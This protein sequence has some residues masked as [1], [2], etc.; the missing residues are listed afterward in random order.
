M[1][2]NINDL[3]NND[4]N[5]KI[6]DEFEFKP[7][8]EGLGFHKNNTSKKV[9]FKSSHLTFDNSVDLPS[10]SQT[11]QNTFKKNQLTERPAST[12]P[13]AQ[14]HFSLQSPLPRIE[15]APLER[16]TTINIPTIEDDSISK[17]QTAVNEILK[18]LNQKKQ[19][20]E[21]LLRNKR[22]M[23]WIN[24]TPSLSAGFLDTML[25]TALFLL[26][27]IAM[28]VITKID[29]V[30][31]LT[32]PDPQYLVYWAGFSLLASVQIIYYVS[33]RTFMG[34]TPGEWAFDQRCGSEL[35]MASTTYVLK[36]LIRTILNAV[37]GFVLFPMI[38]LLVGEDILAKITGVQIQMQKVS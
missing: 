25:V 21:S 27:L 12:K 9:E 32:H 5:D 38:S 36:V 8:T 23:T 35:Q 1:S 29:L 33:C 13:S 4:Q 34:F 10:K 22:K 17:A 28:L 15:D 2:Q 24:A 3:S 26:S 18:T 30:A 31:N 20:E 19:Q 37:T 16:K 14:A 6:F 11:T 7:L